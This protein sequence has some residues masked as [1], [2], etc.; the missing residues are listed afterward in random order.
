M[1]EQRLRQ[2]HGRPAVASPEFLR[3]AEEK[4]PESAG[5]PV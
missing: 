5:S 1:A 4:T 2:R 3:E